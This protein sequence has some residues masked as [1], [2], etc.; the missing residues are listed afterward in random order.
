MVTTRMMMKTSTTRRCMMSH[1]KARERDQKVRQRVV[2][3]AASVS[4]SS[5]P[6]S[7]EGDDDEGDSGEDEDGDDAEGGEESD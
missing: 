3:K 2:H 1:L 6:C 7:G 4:L 5:P